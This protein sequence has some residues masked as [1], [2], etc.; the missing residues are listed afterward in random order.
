[1]KPHPLSPS[2]PT[3]AGHEGGD[4]GGSG[5]RKATQPDV[6]P[7][8]NALLPNAPG[9]S[10]DAPPTISEAV[11]FT[12]TEFI[13]DVKS[14]T[15]A[16]RVMGYDPLMAAWGRAAGRLQS[17]GS[18]DTTNGFGNRQF[19]AV[20]TSLGVPQILQLFAG[21]VDELASSQHRLDPPIAQDQIRAGAKCV[22]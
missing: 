7:L 10:K 17:G 12:Q 13:N 18:W 16:E 4:G 14:M 1:M 15:F 3:P 11:R 9:R 5:K 20:A 21:H 8:C 19:G 2:S 22:Q 6:D